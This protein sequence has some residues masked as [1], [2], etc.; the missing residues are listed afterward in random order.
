MRAAACQRN[1]ASSFF[2]TSGSTQSFTTPPK[3]QPVTDWLFSR[4]P[5]CAQRR[6]HFF[7]TPPLP[8]PRGSQRSL[9]APPSSS[10]RRRSRILP[11]HALTLSLS[12]SLSLSLYLYHYLYHRPVIDYWTVLPTY[13]F[14]NRY[15]QISARI[16][17]IRKITRLLLYSFLRTLIL[18]IRFVTHCFQR[19]CSL[20]KNSPLKRTV[21]PCFLQST[22]M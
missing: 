9:S 5:I 3:T 21:L 22:I 8:A 4:L 11:T 17:C 14:T 20:K 6:P 10:L 16:L 1:L 19:F 7:L 18:F 13:G 2:N 12:L 15:I